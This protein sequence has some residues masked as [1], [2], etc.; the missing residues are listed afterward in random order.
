VGVAGGSD[1]VAGVVAA[2]NAAGMA[3]LAASKVNAMGR[4]KWVMGDLRF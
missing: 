2:A 4:L 3:K 1:G